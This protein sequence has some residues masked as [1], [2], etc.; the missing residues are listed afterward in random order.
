[1]RYLASEREVVVE[2]QGDDWVVDGQPSPLRS[3]VSQSSVTVFGPGG[4]S[5]LIDDPLDRRTSVETPGQVIAPMPGRLTRLFVQSGD[6]VQAGQPL[7]IVEAMKM[8]HT[9][10]AGLAGVVAEL[11]A[12]EG[13]QI[14]AGAV[15]C[16]IDASEVGS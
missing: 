10:T 15:L 1:M 3:F 4:G 5:F 8:E 12:S 11:Q 9:L 7:A 13:A 6:V 2:S 14:E 16:R